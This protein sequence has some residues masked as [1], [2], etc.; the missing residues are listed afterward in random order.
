MLQY[1][2]YTAVGDNS[3]LERKMNIKNAFFILT[4]AILVSACVQLPHQPSQGLPKEEALDKPPHQ[5]KQ[6]EIIKEK[7]TQMDLSNSASAH[8]C[9][10]IERVLALE[11]NRNYFEMKSMQNSNKFRELFFIPKDHPYIKPIEGVV[12]DIRRFSEIF[13]NEYQNIMSVSQR[14]PS[15]GFSVKSVK[16][17]QLDLFNRGVIDE[18]YSVDLDRIVTSHLRDD[19]PV[20]LGVRRTFHDT[21]TNSFPFFYKE[22]VLFATRPHPTILKIKRFSDLKN[23]KSWVENVCEFNIRGK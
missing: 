11:E 13:P 6:A 18:F 22:Q 12:V 4:T 17:Y 2:G 8:I 1:D 3:I 14:E 5:Q 15:E 9:E 20:R 21:T 16:K 19:N 23:R 7:S 10:E